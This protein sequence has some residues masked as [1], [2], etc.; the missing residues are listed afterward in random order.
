MKTN[1]RLIIVLLAMIKITGCSTLT[2]TVIENID[3]NNDKEIAVRGLSY[4]DFQQ[5]ADEAVDSMLRSGVFSRSNHKKHVLA[6]S[7]VI[8]DTMQRIDTDQLIKKIRVALL[9]SG[10]V[11]VT[12]AISAQG[13]EDEMSMRLREMRDNE[14]YDQKT[15]AAKNKMVAADLSLSGKIIQR[16]IRIDKDREQTE[17][18][19]QLTLTDVVRGVS[20]WESETVIGKRGSSNSVSW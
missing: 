6:I 17:Y 10:K 12:T 20:V 5:A 14:E 15:V 3:M 11:V 7:T 9:Q 16:N 19:F 1:S 18:Y 8:N 13:A 2:E 4:Q